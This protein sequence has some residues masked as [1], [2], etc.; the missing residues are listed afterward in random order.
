M[1]LVID[2]ET[3][4]LLAGLDRV[5]SL[6]LR[7]IDKGTIYS[8]ADQPGYRSIASVL[9]L[10]QQAEQIVGHNVIAFDLRALKKVYPSFKLRDDC[11]IYDTLIVSRVL[12]P[13]LDPV[14]RQN[15]SHIE[16]KYMG[17]H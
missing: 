2:A 7:D 6:V 4:D 9:E 3:N 14:D 11:D 10:V 5:H 13:E 8:C 1:R 16:P 17:R 15:F 12:W